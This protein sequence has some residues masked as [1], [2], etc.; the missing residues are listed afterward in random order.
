MNG[1]CLIGYMGSGKS[2]I[3][4]ALSARL[5]LPF[6]DLDHEIEKEENQ[7]IPEIFEKKGEAYFREAESWLLKKYIAVP[8]VLSTGG[9]VIVDEHN[10]KEL[11]KH[12]S[13]IYLTADSS[14]LLERIQQDTRTTRP[15][16][17]EENI[18]SFHRL[19]LER[20]DFYELSAAYQV[21]VTDKSIEEI[22]D[23]II[24]KVSS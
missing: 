23:E 18:D 10:R 2:T 24:H 15:L 9:G 1:I 8:C 11:L 12:E 20:A 16:A 17:M 7:T 6:I 14:I 5:E 21:D 19:F 3:G 13:V 4:K 22:C